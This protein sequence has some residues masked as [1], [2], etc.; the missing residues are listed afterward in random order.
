[1]FGD[2]RRERNKKSLQTHLSLEEECSTNAK[3]RELGECLL[4]V[5]DLKGKISMLLYTL[6]IVAASTHL[7]PNESARIRDAIRHDG[8][9]SPR[10]GMSDRR[11]SVTWR[12]R[13]MLQSR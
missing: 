8:F 6:K 4:Q 10:Q 1:V 3:D 2:R 9:T 5:K 11:H 12:H 7:D 13:R